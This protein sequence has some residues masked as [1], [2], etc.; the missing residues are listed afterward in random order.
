MESIELTRQATI[1]VIDHYL[2]FM[3]FVDFILKKEYSDTSTYPSSIR[4]LIAYRE[5]INRI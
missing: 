4:R 3:C 2:S 5:Y 1:D